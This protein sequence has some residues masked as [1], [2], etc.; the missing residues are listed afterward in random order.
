MSSAVKRTTHHPVPPN[1]SQMRTL[2]ELCGIRLTDLQA[3]QLWQYHR[4]LRQSDQELNLTRIHQFR[5]MVEKLYVDSILPGT[6]I[7]LP[8]PLLDLGTGPGMPGIPLKI[9]YPHL[10]VLLSESR[11]KRREFLDEALISIGLTG[12]SVLPGISAHFEQPVKGVITRAVESI[13]ATLERIRGC[14]SRKGLALFMKGPHCDE[15]VREA[16]VK[17]GSDYRLVDDIAYR[18]PHTPHDRRLVVFERLNEPDGVKRA[19]AMKRHSAR[20][21]ESEH[22]DFFK[23]LKK[24]LSGRGI[25]KEGRALISGSKIVF[26][27]L[28]DLPGLCEAWITEGDKS[29]PPEYAP[30]H[31]EWYQL[32]HPLF[33][34]L[35]TFG[36]RNPLLLVKVPEPQ[37]WDPAGGLPEGCS[38]LV[39]FQDPENVGTVIR[40]AA[41]FGVDQVI[42]LSE[43]AHPFHP[44]S[45]RASGGAVFRVN[46][47]NGPS[48]KDLPE[49]SAIVPLSAVGVN[50]RSM[51]FPATFALLPGIEGPGLPETFRSRAVSIP[52]MPGVESLNAAAAT[53]IALYEWAGRTARE[54]GD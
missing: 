26:E 8:S 41:A 24:L 49:D 45:I 1:L 50:I 21:I 28:R 11:G 36:T 46:L 40:S 33:D 12:I 20:S 27:I 7:D 16:V 31:L 39:P 54:Q 14:L 47:L 32:A 10:E 15:E 4:L 22:N 18:I 2:L 51:A 5:S 42:L 29:P 9:A 48:L 35:D 23:G 38:L 53:A 3:E 19:A 17:F 34:S 6:L 43:S 13:G 52:I 37:S 44:K 25:R 30:A